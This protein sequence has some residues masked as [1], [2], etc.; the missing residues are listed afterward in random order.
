[1]NPLLLATIPHPDP[2]PV[3]AP[4]GLMWFLLLLTFLLHLLPMNFVLGGSILAVF[5]R[6][7][8]A[9]S[10]HHA[11]LGEFFA[12]A[13]P[14]MIAAAVTLGVAPLLLSQVLY[15]RVFFASSVLMAWFWGA[16]IPLLIIA[17]AGAY[18]ISFKGGKLGGAIG[19]V[20]WIVA[21]IFV[22]IGFIYS[23]N[24]TLML[25]SGEH[26]AAYRENPHGWHLNLADPTL[27]PRYLH[28]LFG[29][30]AVS[31]MVV[32]LY[33]LVKWAREE[34]F[35]RWAVRYGAS[36][37]CM[38]TVVNLILGMWWLIKL[39]RETMLRFMGRSMLATIS[40]GAGALIG[41][42]AMMMMGMAITSRTPRGLVRGSAMSLLLTLILM[43]VARDQVRQG[44]LAAAGFQQNPWVQTQWGPLLL[45]LVMLV[46]AIVVVIWMVAKLAAAS[47]D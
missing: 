33:G 1:M 29:A 30:I 25:R 18:L 44:G 26:L 32:A 38:A 47:R 31:A 42:G 46:V 23:N 5:A 21:L 9:A 43:V 15:G 28:M 11:K 37:F 10:P 19:P 45:F 27:I 16:V 6:L 20:S 39:P 8:G 3:P 4:P 17:Y 14:P 12:K 7:R 22:V 2:L 34:E 36:W 35:G 40:M 41:I 13:M 24:M